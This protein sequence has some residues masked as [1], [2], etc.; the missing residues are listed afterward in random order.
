[1]LSSI[2]EALD[3]DLGISILDIGCGSDAWIMVKIK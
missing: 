3:F 1:V 2:A